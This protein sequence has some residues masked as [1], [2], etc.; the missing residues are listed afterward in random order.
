[1]N[2]NIEDK[3]EKP[4]LNKEK[5][6]YIIG[7]I[8]LA[9]VAIVLIALI[10]FREKGIKEQ[11]ENVEELKEIE[12]QEE[13]VETEINNDEPEEDVEEEI[14][15]VCDDLSEYDIPDLHLNFNS[16]Y[17][18]NPNIFAW[19]NIPGTKVDYPILQ[20]P[21]D[22]A[23]YL[24]HNIDGSEG[25]PGCLYTEYYNS[26]EMTSFN[27]IIY[28]HNMKDGSMFHTLHSYEKEDF[29]KENPYIYIFTSKGTIVYKIFAATQYSDKHILFEYDFEKK[30][31]RQKF[32]DTVKDWDNAVVDED[33]DV[34]ADSKL[35]TLSTCV[36]PS[37]SQRYIVVAYMVA[38][39]RPREVKKEE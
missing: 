13:V 31:D 4:K 11:L 22:T 34:T 30:E 26:T 27:T 37:S 1:M 17:S 10:V 23:Y 20:H 28:G 38:D 35:I 39:G 5:L 12:A 6:F 14:Q 3:S 21:T 15:I 25:Y 19:I 2:N 33:A 7:A 24:N 36:S 16:L 32:I 8:F 9:L 18:A 29:F